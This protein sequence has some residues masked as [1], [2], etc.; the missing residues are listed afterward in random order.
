M[1]KKARLRICA[2]CEWIFTIDNQHPQMGG[3][4]KCGFAHYGARY[5]YGAKA[6]Q[7]GKTQEPWRE[8][9]L[10]AF[11]L[12]LDAEIRKTKPLA[13]RVRGNSLFQ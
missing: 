5:V 8:K 4:P 2:S 11:S 13:T 1:S 10:T 12:E 9:K 7:Y 6:Y 3:C